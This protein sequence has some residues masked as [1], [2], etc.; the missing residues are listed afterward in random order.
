M[1]PQYGIRHNRIDEYQVYDIQTLKTVEAFKHDRKELNRGV[2]H[3]RANLA[4]RRWNEASP[5]TDVPMPWCER[6]QRWHHDT[7]GHI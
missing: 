4:R 7:A 3:G 1:K 5:L 2:A 6:C